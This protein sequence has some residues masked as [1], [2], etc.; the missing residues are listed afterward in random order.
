MRVRPNVVLIEYTPNPDSVVAAAGRLC[1]SNADIDAL[2]TRVS[3]K[4]QTKYLTM[5]RKLGHLS[6][7]EHVSF[8]F[9]IEGVSRALLAQITRH[10][11][12]SFSVQSQRY[13][14]QSGED[15]IDYILPPEIEKL[16]DEYAK[17]FADQMDMMDKWYREWLELL[18]EGGKEDARFVLP[19]AAATR[20]VVTM[21]ARELN[22]F[23]AL[24][25]CNRAQW[26]IRDVAWQM[27]KLAHEAAPALFDEC[28]PECLRG[29][30][31]EGKM[32]CGRM[33]EVRARYDREIAGKPEA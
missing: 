5:L 14:G 10:R 32:C 19:N 18:G 7:F 12:A 25:C 31:P 9:G 20:M 8:T 16:G 22:H 27:L 30:C 28:G 26:E 24:R 11:I 15:G 2:R 33:D 17:R 13:V 21:N 4:D 29:R 6:T 23:F 3:E 1:Y